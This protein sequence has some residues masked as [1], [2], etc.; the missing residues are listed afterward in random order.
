[1]AALDKPFE[2]YRGNDEDYIFVS[3]AHAD[4][5]EVYPDISK[6]HEAGLKVYFDEGI[7]PGS[8]WTS[9]LADAIEHCS[10]FVVFLS[11]SAIIS[12]NCIN[13]IE[14]AVNRKRKIFVVH[15]KDTLVPP[16]IELS[17][18]GRQALLK[19]SL[20]I[21][22][23]HLR[24]VETSQALLAGGEPSLTRGT[25]A[26]K[27]S[28]PMLRVVLLSLI[29]ILAFAAIYYQQSIVNPELRV[30]IA[31]RPFDTS[32]V[33]STR[34]FAD[35]IADDLIMRLGHWRALPIIARG[36]TFSADLPK[37]PVAAGNTLNARY[38]LDGVVSRS[39]DAIRIALHLVDAADGT[40]V[41]SQAFE[42]EPEDAVMHQAAIADAVVAQINPALIEAETRRAVRADPANL[43]AWSAA[44]RG[45]W[46]LNTETKEGLLEA[47]DWFQRSTE[48][49]PS[50][51]WPN[52]ALALSAYRALINN[53]TNDPRASVGTLVQAANKAVQLDPRDAF[54]HHALGHAYAMQGKIDQSL[55]ALARG[56][57][58]SPNDPMTN[59]C[60]AMQ[61]AASSRSAEALETMNHV[62]AISANDPWEHRFALVRA[63]AH[64]AAEN[65]SDAEEWAL[66]SLQL[67]PT[68]GAFLHSV[69]APA[70]NNGIERAQERVKLAK[71][72]RALPPLAGIE[73]GFK[74][75][76]EHG[77]VRR[78]IEG[79][80]LAGFE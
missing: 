24:L 13:E 69:A 51:S 61:L 64:F 49:D 25:P 53:W 21:E 14:F 65:Y 59:G 1:M 17:L 15:L 62:F 20:D 10:L 72:E 6:L 77:Y 71:V 76:T 48:L 8:R 47:N 52:S 41:W 4:S 55:D 19:H 39:G 50:W 56:V 5:D 38:I 29:A 80:R 12:E 42:H 27:P 7:S 73:Q 34:F 33:E 44:M 57:E 16:G 43:D 35:G 75:S 26:N 74:R 37:D 68:N 11:P 31:V 46:H 23:Y 45:W 54:A 32:S 70:L 9:E 66:R 22:T 40:K 2:A 18:G 30:A 78:L 67:Q 3:Y 79:L 58:L 60:Y 36:S 63:R 28:R